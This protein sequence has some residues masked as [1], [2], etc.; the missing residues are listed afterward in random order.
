MNFSLNS[1]QEVAYFTARLMF[2]LN[3]YGKKNKYFCQNTEL[4]R[5]VRIPFSSLLAYKRAKGKIIILSAFTSSSEDKEFA[6]GWA[7]RDTQKSNY[8]GL[9]SVVFIIKN[10]W[11]KEWI[12][13][14]IDLQEVTHY[15]EEKEILFEPFTF[16]HVDD[17]VFDVK[18]YTADIYLETIGKTEILENAIKNG[19]KIEYNEELNIMEV[20]N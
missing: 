6:S 14:G 9:F 8:D 18:K 12:S 4:Y 19:K 10:I 15:K 16:C 13:N 5:G 2:S 7:G 17:V 3:N 1:F 20:K 11:K